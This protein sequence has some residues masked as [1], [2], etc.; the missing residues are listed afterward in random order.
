MKIYHLF[1]TTSPLN[2]SIT[3]TNTT[4]PQRKLASFTNSRTQNRHNLHHSTQDDI[5]TLLDWQ[6]KNLFVTF[7]PLT[8]GK[9]GIEQGNNH[10]I[11]LCNIYLLFYN[12]TPS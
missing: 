9:L 3:S 10:S 6:L 12:I 7:G 2:A 8:F 1:F 11:P 4:E 5:I